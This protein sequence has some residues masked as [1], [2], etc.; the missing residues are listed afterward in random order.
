MSRRFRTAP[1]DVL[2]ELQEEVLSLRPGTADSNVNV[3]EITYPVRY[4]LILQMRD[5]I[6]RLRQMNSGN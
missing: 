5:E 1:R 2:D 6:K 4:G 3:F